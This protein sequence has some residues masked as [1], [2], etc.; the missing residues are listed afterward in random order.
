VA[1]QAIGEQEQ[2]RLEQE[3]ERAGDEQQHHR[4]LGVARA[5]RAVDVGR[6]D[7]GHTRGELVEERERQEEPRGEDDP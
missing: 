2:R 6:A 3:A 7:R 4:E 5:E 1:R